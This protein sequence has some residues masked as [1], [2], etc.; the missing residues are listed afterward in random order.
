[1]IMR[2]S[3]EEGGRGGE[4]AGDGFDKGSPGLDAGWTELGID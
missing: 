3:S 1:M 2:G 4:G